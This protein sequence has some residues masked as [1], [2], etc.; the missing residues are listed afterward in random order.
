ML[1][2]HYS[3]QTK[4]LDCKHKNNAPVLCDSSIR[5]VLVLDK[6]PCI[7]HALEVVCA[8][9]T[10][11]QDSEAAPAERGAPA[12]AQ[13]GPRNHKH[14]KA[15]VSTTTDKAERDSPS[16]LHPM[17][18]CTHYIA[19]LLILAAQTGFAGGRLEKGSIQEALG[20]IINYTTT[21]KS[22]PPVFVLAASK[23]S[24]RMYLLG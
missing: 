4:S 21:Q 14:S 13:L 17:I 7:P 9:H 20:S 6:P 16:P 3:L 19:A 22:T 12:H 8:T 1:A 2:I 18:D 15:I 5:V 11:H 10:S 23:T 24:N